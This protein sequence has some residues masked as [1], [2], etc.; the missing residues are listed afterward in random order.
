MLRVTL[1]VSTQIVVVYLV[2]F[3]CLV[4]QPYPLSHTHPPFFLGTAMMTLTPNLSL[5]QQ[6]PSFPDVPLGL[7]HRREDELE[8]G[9]DTGYGLS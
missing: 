5:S 2:L 3:L 8:C 1:W 6:C 7:P 4:T 9:S